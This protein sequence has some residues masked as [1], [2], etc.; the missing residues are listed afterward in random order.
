MNIKRNLAVVPLIAVFLFGIG[1][2]AMVYVNMG[3][4]KNLNSAVG[5]RHAVLTK[6]GTLGQDLEG[7]SD[8]LLAAPG[9]EGNGIEALALKATQ[10]REQLAALGAL[11]GQGVL[12]GRLAEEFDIWYRPAM[13]ARIMHALKPGDR[14]AALIVFE[15][16]YRILQDDLEQA[17]LEALQ[18]FAESAAQ[19]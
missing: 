10:V 12:A 4:I 13:Q 19:N 9:R 5:S 6:L 7:L 14:D 17:R 15:E 2:A 3:A 18:Q 8:D 1:L 11:P 16:H